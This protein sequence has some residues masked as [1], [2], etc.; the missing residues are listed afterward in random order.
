M[1]EVSMYDMIVEFLEELDHT[2]YLQ[3]VFKKVKRHNM[4]LNLEKFTFG[5]HV[6]KILAFYL[7]ERDIKVNPNKF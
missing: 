1:V 2:T 6:R 7:T 4:R 5:V 3:E